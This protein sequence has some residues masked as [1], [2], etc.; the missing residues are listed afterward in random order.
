MQLD[1]QLDVLARNKWR[2]S[3]RLSRALLLYAH[4]KGIETL[5]RHARE[6][7]PSR[8]FVGNNPRDGKLTPYKGHPV[9]V[10]QHATATCCR[11]AMAKW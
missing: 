11:R 2:G 4:E 8:V 7:L 6:I 10:A 3:K 1:R 5:E 9:F